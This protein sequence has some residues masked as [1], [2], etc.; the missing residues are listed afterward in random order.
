MTLELAT[1]APAAEATAGT[2]GRWPRGRSLLATLRWV[3][4]AGSG[5]GLL[6]SFGATHACSGKQ[7]CLGG[8]DGACQPQSACQVLSF[9]CNVPEL[10]IRRLTDASERPR[11][12]KAA[13]AAGDLLLQN[14]R[15]T[16]ILDDISSPHQLAP[17]G[18]ALLDLTVRDAAASD[19]LNQAMQA[20]GILPDDAASYRKL[21]I[22][23]QRPEFV[24]VVFR[25]SLDLRPE[26]EIVTRYELRACEPGLRVRSEFYHSGR[27]PLTV[28]A[29]DAFFWGDRGITPFVPLPGRG[30]QHPELDLETIGEAFGDAPFVA[31]DAHVAGG[32]A[33]AVVPCDRRLLSGFH[34]DTL[35][36]VGAPR[37]LL[38]P[39]DSLAFERFIGVAPGPGQQGA[40]NLAL[41]LR[42]QLFGEPTVTVTGRIMSGG[43]PAGG[44][45]RR[46]SL[47]FYEPAASE[48]PDDERGRW[49]RSAAVPDLQG[50]FE[51]RLPAGRRY[52]VE[53]HALGRPIASP[54]PFVATEHDVDLGELVL[55]ELGRLEVSVEDEN[56]APLI[57]EVVL[58]P[59]TP[60]TAESARGS[61]FGQHQ[62][63]HCTPYL[64]PPHGGSPACNRVLLDGTGSQTFLAPAGEF[65][66]YAT[67]GPFWTLGR[68]RLEIVAG[69][70]ASAR[71]LL[72]PLALVPAGMLSADFHVHGGASF[73]SSLPDRDRALSFVAT[74]VDVLA[75]TDHDV[76][77][78]YEGAIAALGIGEHVR[79][80][81]GVETTGQ[82]LFLEPPGAD[83]PK[84]IG[85]FNFWPL[86]YDF[87]RARNGAPDDERLEP[88]ALF[89]R[90]EPLYTGQGVA[91]LNHPYGDS[92]LGRD[93]GYLAA[94]GYDP[95]VPV[96]PAPDGSTA[97]QLARRPLGRRSNLD[98]D[99]QEVMSGASVEQFARYRTGWFS[100][101]NQGIV[102]AGTANSD[103]HTLAVEVLGYPRNLVA[104]GHTLAAFDLER[105][106]QSVRQGEMVGTNGPVLEVCVT[107]K[108]ACRT[109]SLQPFEPGPDAV[110]QIQVSAAPWIPVEEVRVWVN[111]SLS[112]QFS[113]PITSADPFGHTA[114]Q[115]GFDRP[116]AEL[117]M[118]RPTVEDVWIVVEAGMKL[119][120]FADL[121]DDGI[122]ETTDNNGDGQVDARDVRGRFT[123]P[124]RVSE[125][126]PRFHVQAVAP[127]VLPLAFSNPLLVDRQGDG[128]T[129]PGLK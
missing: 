80:I 128:W 87:D 114:F 92:S 95:R 101:L 117:L 58:I 69:E 44:E 15:I 124:G 48:N 102:R 103:S 7:G 70:T 126:D 104:G 86:S 125:S 120:A 12:P 23:D 98:F 28:F 74:G 115:I 67:R 45:E 122:P 39:G 40:V 76:V 129:A 8:D 31:G 10:A 118:D 21:E 43:A 109:P 63:P 29:A 108:N 54:L 18:G 57:A 77:T 32:V 119:P 53:P 52:R 41:D 46:A 36:A 59:A 91:Q 81:P 75:A 19:Q 99:V 3:R 5:L 26:I 121:D 27:D 4:R 51:V 96:P 33:Y 123:E 13:A 20:V 24:A 56:G 94:L 72:R 113:V 37:T 82:I 50:R 14:D 66:V 111:G 2:D 90:I 30:F 88:G 85:H 55:P 62:E 61:V 9:H 116:L 16:A 107:G 38:M 89:E 83:V 79:V 110:L 17:S 42:E 1:R 22:I 60:E 93:I 65:F 35:S 100:F 73:D 84:V 68:E 105:F 64:G 78:S 71:F 47:L 112:A 97:G 25:G 127:G 11:G 6:A 49:P 106:D 34:S